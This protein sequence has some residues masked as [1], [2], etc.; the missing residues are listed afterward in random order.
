[1]R[2]VF[3]ELSRIAENDNNMLENKNSRNVDFAKQQT[4]GGSVLRIIVALGGLASFAAVVLFVT[5]TYIGSPKERMLKKQNADYQEQL[6]ELDKKIANLDK[7]LS[8]IEQR[9]DEV[10]RPI[11]NM[12]A[13]AVE[14]RQ[15]GL[16]GADRYVFL[17]GY[18]NSNQMIS[19]AQKLDQLGRKLYIQQ[20][21]FKELQKV[22]DKNKKLL[23]SIP[24]IQP[25]SVGDLNYISSFY[26][27]RNHPKLHRWIKHKGVDYAAPKGSPI[28]ATGDGVV[29]HLKSSMLNYGK[30]VVINHGF[31]YE[32]LYAH[33]NKRIV[34]PGDSVKR[35][36]VI[37]YVGR[38]GRVTGVHLH[39]EVLKD[40]HS[41][42]PRKFYQEDLTAEEY[43]Q[44][45]FVLSL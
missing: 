14:Q 22:A 23:A 3:I 36:Q 7:V 30:V 31:G 18:H 45:I 44:M 27:Y 2:F 29:E 42:N 5:Y 34:Q 41:I 10:Y 20:K 25:V 26:G 1:M 19:T 40:G 39:Y 21:S 35:G 9:D 15:V 32:T 17:E 37:G 33:M 24:A 43:D 16:G 28:Y 12:E 13:V 8:E 38:T 6:L 4:F 11:C